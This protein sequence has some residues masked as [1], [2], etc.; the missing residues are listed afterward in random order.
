MNKAKHLEMWKTLFGLLRQHV[1]KRVILFMGGYAAKYGYCQAYNDNM[2]I[3]RRW[4]REIVENWPQ[5]TSCT[6][7]LHPALAKYWKKLLVPNTIELKEAP[8]PRKRCLKAFSENVFTESLQAS[9]T[10]IGWAVILQKCMPVVLN[11]T[12]LVHVSFAGDV[13]VCFCREVW[14]RL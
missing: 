5:Q 6:S 14:K 4:I 10:E 7:M 3:I 12:P 8:L 9:A 2:K 1:E 11:K 13:F